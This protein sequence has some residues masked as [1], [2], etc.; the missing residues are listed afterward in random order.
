MKK[1]ILTGS[2]TNIN[3]LFGML[4]LQ[5]PGL[6]LKSE[7]VDIEP[8]VYSAAAE[9]AAAKA[10]AAAA[11]EAEAAAKK[12]EAEAAAKA[13]ASGV[14]NVTGKPERDTKPDKTANNLT[15]K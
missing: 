6:G 1:L 5:I 2:A 4:E 14:E 9:A 12:A 11:A 15:K 3:S 10:E 7:M 13:K 8:E